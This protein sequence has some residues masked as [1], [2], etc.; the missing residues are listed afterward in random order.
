M[1][2][3]KL[4]T[5]NPHHQILIATLAMFVDDFGYTTRELFELMNHSQKQLWSALVE[6]EKE[7]SK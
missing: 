1:D 3:T 5:N 7:K 6:M 4:D 2:K